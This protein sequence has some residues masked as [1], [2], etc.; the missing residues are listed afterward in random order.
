MRER[1]HEIYAATFYGNT[2]VKRDAKL[3]VA[4]ALLLPPQIP[5]HQGRAEVAMTV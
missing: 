3:I 5:H 4:A 1:R 2:L